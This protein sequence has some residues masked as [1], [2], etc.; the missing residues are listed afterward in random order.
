MALVRLSG[1]LRLG[2][3]SI[4]CHPYSLSPQTSKGDRKANQAVLK[5]L[6]ENPP[7]IQSQA[8]LRAAIF[9]L[10]HDQLQQPTPSQ[11]PRPSSPTKPPLEGSSMLIDAF[12]VAA[13]MSPIVYYFLDA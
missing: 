10:L 3:P 6:D 5:L 1:A 11:N 7:S 4:G 2:A 9:G 8:P 13:L 12:V